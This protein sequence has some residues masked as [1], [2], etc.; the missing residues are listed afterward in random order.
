MPCR[1]P[2]PNQARRGKYST[3]D[4]F[5]ADVSY[6]CRVQIRGISTSKITCLTTIW[7]RLKSHVIVTA[8]LPPPVRW[9]SLHRSGSFDIPIRLGSCLG[10]LGHFSGCKFVVERLKRVLLSCSG[11][12]GGARREGCGARGWKV[13]TGAREVK[14]IIRKWPYL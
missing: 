14:R 9:F 2:I 13:A 6:Q 10:G 11:A 1:W 4:C 8:T 7:P 3:Q 12:I 5:V